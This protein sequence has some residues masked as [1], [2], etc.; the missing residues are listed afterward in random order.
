MDNVYITPHI[1]GASTERT[2]VAYFSKVI[3]DHEAGLPLPN[4]VDRERGY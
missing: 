2:G 3:L 4:V 1:A